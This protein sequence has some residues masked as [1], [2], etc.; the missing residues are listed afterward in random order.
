MEYKFFTE[1][2]AN[3]IIEIHQGTN[4]ERKKKFEDE[5]FDLHYDELIKGNKVEEKWLSDIDKNNKLSINELLTL[6]VKALNNGIKCLTLNKKDNL[7]NIKISMFK[8]L[9]N[10][11]KEDTT[12]IMLLRYFLYIDNANA[13]A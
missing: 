9:Q 2:E 10:E 8:F 5:F 4:T 11:I 13:T 1:E 7:E 3:Y 12:S 6:K